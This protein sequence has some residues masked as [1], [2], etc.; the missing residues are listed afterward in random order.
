VRLHDRAD[1]L[2]H[3]ASLFPPL[4]ALAVT[5]TC[6]AVPSLLLAQQS[7]PPVIRPRPFATGEKLTYAITW[8]AIRAGTAI[9]GVVDG[10]MAHDRPALKLVT[11]A[12]ASPFVSTFYPVNTSVE[13]LIDAETLTP[14]RLIFHR[15]EGRRKNDFDVTFH[16]SSNT[17][18]S[19]KDGHA[20]NL[21]VP[22]DVQDAISS[23]YYARASLPIRVGSR[24]VLNVHH[25]QKNYRLVVVGEGVESVKGSW[26]ETEAIRVL[27]VM[28]FQ[29]IF[30]N[31]GNIRVWLTRDARRLP[32][33]MKAKVLIGTVVATLIDGFAG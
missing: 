17:V 20:A 3:S 18:T 32:L 27:V 25:D 6:L 2:I 19:I 9:M 14:H 12:T 8:L 26:G 11:T 28:P 30:L 23:L 29:G 7:D 16:R 33:M 21:T 22:A 4:F 13:S 31:E 1:R 10:G 15:R 24:F 5:L